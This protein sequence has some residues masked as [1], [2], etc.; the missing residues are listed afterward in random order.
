MVG[1]HVHVLDPS[2]R[3]INRYCKIKREIVIVMIVKTLNQ[4]P[5]IRPRV[6]LKCSINRLSDGI[7]LRI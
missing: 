3:E 1:P 6:L 4:P 2:A 5:L 7:G